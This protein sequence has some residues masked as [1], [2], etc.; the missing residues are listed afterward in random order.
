MQALPL[1]NCPRAVHAARALIA[2]PE[3]A[4]QQPLYVRTMAWQIARDRAC[5]DHVRYHLSHLPEGA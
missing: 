5:R 3:R 1:L 2:D 4:A